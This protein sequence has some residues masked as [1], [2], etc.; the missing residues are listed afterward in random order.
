MRGANGIEI[1][2]ALRRKTLNQH[3][4]HSRSGDEKISDTGGARSEIIQTHDH[5]NRFCTN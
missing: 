4:D 2:L 1:R 3:N 5:L